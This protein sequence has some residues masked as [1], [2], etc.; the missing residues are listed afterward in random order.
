[1]AHETVD[2]RS[3]VNLKNWSIPVFRLTLG[4]EN[5]LSFYMVSLLAAHYVKPPFHLRPAATAG[6]RNS[7]FGPEGEWSLAVVHGCSVC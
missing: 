7:G 1:M 3:Q 4:R 2:G 6:D 5:K